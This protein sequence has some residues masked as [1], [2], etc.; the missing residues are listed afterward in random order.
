MEVLVSYLYGGFFLFGYDDFR[1]T[2][3]LTQFFF[4]LP[5]RNISLISVFG[6]KLIPTLFLF[7]VRAILYVEGFHFFWD[8]AVQAEVFGL[9]TIVC[10]TVH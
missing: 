5:R 3:S 2:H 8:L 9:L 4:L 10:L 6:L 7:H 1:L